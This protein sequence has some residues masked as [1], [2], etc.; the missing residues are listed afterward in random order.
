MGCQ[1]RAPAQGHGAEPLDGNPHRSVVI[2]YSGAVQF[3]GRE[4]GLR[5]R[6]DANA[7]LAP[8]II[9]TDNR[10]TFSER[11][12]HMQAVPRQNPSTKAQAGATIVIAG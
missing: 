1:Y 12:H 7:H 8:L 3:V 2:A 11:A 4:C 6:N 9:E 5:V 10:G